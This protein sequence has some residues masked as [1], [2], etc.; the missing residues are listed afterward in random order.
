MEIP[1]KPNSSS[2]RMKIRKDSTEDGVTSILVISTAARSHTGSYTCN[3][4]NAFGRDSR[5]IDLVVQG[6]I[7]K[8]G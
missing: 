7:K 2:F 1:V 6:N 5:V 4:A 8:R 3:A